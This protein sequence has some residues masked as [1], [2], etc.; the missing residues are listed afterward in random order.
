MRNAV[1]RWLSARFGMQGMGLTVLTVGCLCPTIVPAQGL[2]PDTQRHVETLQNY[3]QTV[4][5]KL[6]PGAPPAAPAT[7][8]QPAATPATEATMSELPTLSSP[9][10]STRGG[11]AA[12]YT[13]AGRDPFAVTPAMLDNEHFTLKKEIDFIPL[14]GDFKIPS[15]RLKG[16]ITGE[17]ANQPLAALLKIDGLGVFVVREGDSVGLQG[18]G[19]GRDVIL[20]E[21]ISRLSLVVRTGSYGGASEK[22]FVVR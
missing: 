20:I 19:N 14:Q 10:S 21:S 8:Q 13:P 6:R 22:R 2:D 9:V 7:V 16:V 1:E 15:M 12:A 5:D 3:Y 18:I 4:Q 17:T 11:T